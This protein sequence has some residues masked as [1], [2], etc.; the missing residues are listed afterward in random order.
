M[1]INHL[2]I[3]ARIMSEFGLL[4]PLLLKVHF[5]AIKCDFTFLFYFI[6]LDMTLV[7]VG[8]CVSRFILRFKLIGA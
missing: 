6:E 4:M 1:V 3:R 8:L 5:S 2:G 7:I